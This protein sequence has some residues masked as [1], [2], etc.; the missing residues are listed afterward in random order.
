MNTRLGKQLFYIIVFLI[1]IGL[2]GLVI[3]VIWLKPAPTCFDKKQNQNET[4]VDCGGSCEDCEIR[5]LQQPSVKWSKFPAG[6][7]TILL[8][9]LRNL[10]PKYGAENFFYNFDILGSDGKK[11]KSLAS[12]SFIYAGEIKY[13]IEVIGFDSR[14]I[15]KVE[16]SFSSIKWKRI[17]QFTKPEV[18]L[19]EV[20]TE[21]A[22]PDGRAIVSGFI[23]NNNAFP[24]SKIRI[25]GVLSNS[26]DIQISASKTELENVK[27]NEEK[28]FKIIFPS[29][30]SLKGNPAP[31]PTSTVPSSFAFK[32]DLQ[33]GSK[34]TDVVELQKFLKEKG[35]FNREPTDYFGSIT[36]T[37]LINYQKSVK[38]SP[39]SGYFGPKTREYINSVMGTSTTVQPLISTITAATSTGQTS[40]GEA[41][42]TKTKVYLEAVR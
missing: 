40:L 41:D 4:G 23:L 8:I 42:P 33:V 17:D 1:I 25:V 24:L 15:D 12:N 39:A 5:T 35:F 2:I 11:I 31:A 14:D 3:Y 7:E 37:A 30:I 22:Q 38:I 18:Q 20:K 9:E 26:N 36:K 6:N 29:N 32:R 13:L 34:G 16:P 27:A 10:N 19:R 28:Q 21:S